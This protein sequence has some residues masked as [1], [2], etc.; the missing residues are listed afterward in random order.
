M[1][2]ARDQEAA[3]RGNIASFLF[4]P[5]MTDTLRR[6][7]SESSESENGLFSDSQPPNRRQRLGA[8]TDVNRDAVFYKDEGDCYLR[9]EDHLFKIHRYQLTREDAS[10]FRDMFLLPSG[11][12]TS[13]GS[14]ESDPIVLAGDTADR[15]RAFLSIAYAD[16][17]EFQVVEAHP[18]QLVTLVHFAHFSHKYNL[19][20]FTLAALEVILLPLNADM[21]F[22]LLALS[23]LCEGYLSVASFV[24]YK[25][26][27]QRSVVCTWL[28][29]L[30]P[31]REITEL[32]AAMD[33][34]EQYDLH[35]LLSF[36]SVI[37]L[38]RV[39]E[40]PPDRTPSGIIAPFLNHLWLKLAHRLRLLT[41]AWALERAWIEFSGT[42][43]PFPQNHICLK[44][45]HATVCTQRWSDEWQRAVTSF[46]VLEISS[47]NM[48][49]RAAALLAVMTPAF[50][51]ACISA[52]FTHPNPI[53]VFA[54]NVA[55]G[56]HF[57]DVCLGLN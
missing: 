32:S 36:T 8:T 26:S 46:R 9:A 54:H 43:P 42:P 1:T 53:E 48:I 52:A 34:G 38:E 17:L 57:T 51:S 20:P 49:L 3:T 14:E 23:F 24:T 44:P 39:A 29:H 5:A 15:F 13:Q 37:Y 30:D 27:L 21:Y 40:Q 16:P 11:D 28:K 41:G 7:R 25:L 18:E 50:E 4:P 10:V 31:K 35:Y 33:A 2:E 56:S 19:T 6:Q 12:H 22:S 45:N 55:D 47:S